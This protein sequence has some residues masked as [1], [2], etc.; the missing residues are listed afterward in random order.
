MI[1]GLLTGLLGLIYFLISLDVIKAR[2]KHQISL[3]YG[4][5]N[6]IASIVSAHGNFISY[7]PFLLILL[8]FIEISGV[9]HWVVILIFGGSFFIGRVLHYL[10]FRSKKMNF[11]LRKLGMQLT[12]YPLLI[13]AICNIG[14]FFYKAFIAF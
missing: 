8:Y 10:S 1:T 14:I 11:K 12:L 4:K 9:F 7:T 3:G 6:E 2:I 13:M 5:N